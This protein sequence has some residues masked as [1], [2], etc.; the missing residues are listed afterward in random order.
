M[1]SSRNDLLLTFHFCPLNPLYLV[2]LP[3]YKA[4]NQNQM[5][6]VAFLQHLIVNFIF[7]PFSSWTYAQMHTNAQTSHTVFNLAFALTLCC[8]IIK[9]FMSLILSS[10]DSRWVHCVFVFV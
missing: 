7:S 3:F 10:F 2:A 8:V 6:L 1:E 5:Y 9:K 4:F